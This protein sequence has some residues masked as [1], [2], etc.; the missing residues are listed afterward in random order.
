VAL[1][2]RLAAERADLGAGPAHERPEQ[3][4]PGGPEQ[5]LGLGDDL[6][7]ASPVAECAGPDSHPEKGSGGA[8]SGHS[9]GQGPAAPSGE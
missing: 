2:V 7:R 4:E 5:D 3:L 8:L 1:G 6:Q 9:S